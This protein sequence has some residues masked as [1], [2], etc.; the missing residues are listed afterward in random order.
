[1]SMGVGAFADLVLE[2]ENTLIYQY[3]GFNLNEAEYE[4]ASR[5]SDGL[6]TIN[7]SCL[8]E[9]EIHEKLKRLPSGRKKPIVKRIPVCVDYPKMIKG[10][11]TVENCSNCWKTSED[12]NNIDV[13][14]GWLLF[15]F[16]QEYQETGEIPKELRLMS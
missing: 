4:N 16:F 7:K 15:Y 3:G 1:M 12:E 5:I 9:P 2:D 14:A 10:M 8:V 13:S 6:I 11:I